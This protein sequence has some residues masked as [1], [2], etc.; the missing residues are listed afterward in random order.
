[1][2]HLRSFVFRRRADPSQPNGL[3][4]SRFGAQGRSKSGAVGLANSN[5][6]NGILRPDTIDRMR[7]Q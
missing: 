7:P 3:K 2:I 4:V 6:G 1:M 5:L